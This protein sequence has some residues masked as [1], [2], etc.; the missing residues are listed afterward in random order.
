MATLEEIVF[1]SEN[2]VFQS[3]PEGG[4]K[5]SISASQPEA[6]RHYHADT[7]ARAPD[8]II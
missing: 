1:A 7:S 4:W 5:R 3:P 6:D 2:C 8:L